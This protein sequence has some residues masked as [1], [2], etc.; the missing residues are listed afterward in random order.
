VRQ[1]AERRRAGERIV[2]TNGCFDLLHVGH[3]RA[4]DDAAS[5]G[6]FLIVC[7]N[8]DAEVR[9][10]KGPDR[11]IFPAGERAE[12]LAGLRSVDAVLVFSEPTVDGILRA[13]RPDV[14]AKGTDY[15]PENVPEGPTV[16]EYGGEIAIVGDPKDHSSRSI[17]AR[18]RGADR[19][20]S[21]R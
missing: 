2:L 8:D 3:L 16:R 9:R 18:L 14:Y 17:L 15:T 21:E 19:G 11:P 7:V 10:T 12:L 4:I 6:D 5:R 1:V 13:I 20:R